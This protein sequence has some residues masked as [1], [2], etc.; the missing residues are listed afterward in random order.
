MGQ[1][2]HVPVLREVHCCVSS[3]KLV[4]LRNLCFV[5]SDCFAVAVSC[6]ARLVSIIPLFLSS[7]QGSCFSLLDP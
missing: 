2:T 1:G 7:F 3:R 4:F 5:A 6:A